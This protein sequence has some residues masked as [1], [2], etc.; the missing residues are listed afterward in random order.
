MMLTLGAA[1]SQPAPTAD[2]ST[3]RVPAYGDS[4]A[5]GHRHKPH[6]LKALGNSPAAEQLAAC[7]H[8]CVRAQWA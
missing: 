3:T 4:P 8:V 5:M 6:S 2:A 1:R 7:L